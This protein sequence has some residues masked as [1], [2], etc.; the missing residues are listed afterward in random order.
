MIRALATATKN[1]K[2][3]GL[4]T[5]RVPLDLVSPTLGLTQDQVSFYSLARNFADEELRPYATSW[6]ETATFPMKTFEKFGELGFAGICVRD[7]VGGSALS[8]VDS[9]AIIEALATGCVGTTAML[10]IHNMCSGMIDKFGS[11]QQRKKWLQSF[12]TWG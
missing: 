10:T 11:E 9:C 12:D 6:D 7:D 8:R 5:S 2:F 3:R 1:A 4:A